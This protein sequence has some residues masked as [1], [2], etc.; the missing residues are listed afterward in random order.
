MRIHAMTG[1]RYFSECC[2]GCDD[3]ALSRYYYDY[4]D[5]A[6]EFEYECPKCGT[7]LI[8]YVAFDPTFYCAS[9]DEVPA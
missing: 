3:A 6:E 2:E 1:Q 9:A 4:A 8:V 7:K 5:Y